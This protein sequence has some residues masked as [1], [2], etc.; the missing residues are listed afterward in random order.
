MIYWLI[1]LFVLFVL[2]SWWLGIG[3]AIILFA[4]GVI[5]WRIDKSI[6]DEREDAGSE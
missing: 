4:G 2:L 5:A 3:V 6:N 1:G